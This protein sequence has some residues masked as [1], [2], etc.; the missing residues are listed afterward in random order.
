M[1]KALTDNLVINS[2]LI[3]QLGMRVSRRC[4]AIFWSPLLSAFFTALFTS[5][6]F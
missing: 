2:E 4:L 5:G 6:L 3:V 1:M